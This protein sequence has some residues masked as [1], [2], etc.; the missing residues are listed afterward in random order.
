MAQSLT[1]A[2][3]NI[4]SVRDAV[5]G[6]SFSGGENDYR[7]SE[8][9]GDWN[10]GAWGYF[11]RSD[12]IEDRRRQKYSQN[13]VAVVDYGAVGRE[14]GTGFDYDYLSMVI[15]NNY[16]NFF[17]QGDDSPSPLAVDAGINNINCRPD[18]RAHN[19][20]WPD[21]TETIAMQRL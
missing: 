7:V 21:V 2:L 19:A 14:Q 18:P 16:Y 9:G 4:G 17:K 3:A 15:R 5:S 11:R 1:Q 12:D 20:G 10:I 8:G 13:P 6:G